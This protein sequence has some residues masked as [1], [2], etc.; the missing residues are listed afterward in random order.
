MFDAARAGLLAIGAPVAPDIGRTHGGLISAFG[1]Y[2]V[3]HGPVS[4]EMGR[5]LNRALEVRQ[6]ADYKSD[7]V[8][9]IDAQEMV[10]QAEAFLAAIGAAFPSVENASDM[11]S[12]ITPAAP[13][14]TD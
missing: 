11:H 12:P 4:R 13:P 5:L 10:A 14:D 2:V 1:N 7:S 6:I 8:E 9:L 3:K